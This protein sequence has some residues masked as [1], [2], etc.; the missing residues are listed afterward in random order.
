MKTKKQRKRM[1][2]HASQF[3][4]YVQCPTRVYLSIYGDKSKRLAVSDFMQKKM[5]EGIIH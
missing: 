4:N 5:E 1:M 2:M 3:Y